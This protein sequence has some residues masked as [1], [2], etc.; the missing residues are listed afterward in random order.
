ML[1]LHIDLHQ[2]PEL[3]WVLFC[4]QDMIAQKEHVMHRYSRYDRHANLVSRMADVAG[5]DL[6]EETQRGN[7]MP[8]ALRATIHNCMGCSDPSG[9]EKWLGEH[10]NGSSGTPDYCRN[11][12]L[13]ST[14]TKN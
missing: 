12:A 13:F 6:A 8:E 11:A 4:K 1:Q 2:G 14:L 10:Q 9:C 5:V 3:S 7:L